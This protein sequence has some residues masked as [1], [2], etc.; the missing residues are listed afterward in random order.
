VKVFQGHLAESPSTLLEGLNAAYILL[1][2]ASK[3]LMYADFS[4]SVDTTDQQA[5]GMRGKAYSMFG[6]VLSATSFLQP[7]ILAIGRDILTAWIAQSS[8][9]EIYQHS[10]NDGL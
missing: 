10:L 4:Y 3:A 2:R 1:S 6:Q 9:L 7:E 5:A 8:G